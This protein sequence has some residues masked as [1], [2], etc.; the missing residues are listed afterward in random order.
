MKGAPEVLVL[1]ILMYMNMHSL[2]LMHFKVFWLL[3]NLFG[4]V[5]HKK[6]G[7][8]IRTKKKF[9]QLKIEHMT[10]YQGINLYIKKILKTKLMK[11]G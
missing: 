4:V 9:K 11:N 3:E 10:R 5:V 7:K 1:S 6:N 8:R 2:L